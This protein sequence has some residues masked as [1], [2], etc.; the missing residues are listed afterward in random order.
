MMTHAK[1]DSAERSEPASIA[2]VG[3]VAGSAA[4]YYI[5][6]M[7]NRAIGLRMD[8]QTIR[9]L[10]GKRDPQAAI[11]QLKT[12]ERDAKALRIELAK[13]NGHLPLPNLRNEPRTTE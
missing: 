11:N 8:A 7:E 1:S 6:G 9:R 5:L 10:I 3:S 12:M 2:H 4:V 13:W